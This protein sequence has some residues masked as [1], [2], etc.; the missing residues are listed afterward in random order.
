MKKSSKKSSSRSSLLAWVLLPVFVALCVAAVE[1]FCQL[2]LLKLK[3]SERTLSA[4]D[5]N[6]DLTLVPG[7][8]V[9][10]DRSGYLSCL[11]VI[12]SS[13]Q[14]QDLVLTLTLPDGSTRQVMS[15]FVPS[16]GQDTIR[17]GCE[18]SGLS[19]ESTLC[20]M[21]VTG[22]QTDNRFF[23]HGNRALL[24]ALV[25]ACLWLLIWFRSFFSAKP[26]FA[27]LMIALTVGIYLSVGLPTA[28]GLSWDDQIHFNR[29]QLLSHGLDPRSTSFTDNLY[30]LAFNQRHT[31]PGSSDKLSYVPDTWQDQQAY[32]AMLDHEAE[33]DTAWNPL[34]ITH[35]MSDVGYLL[36]A[37][38]MGLSRLLGLPFHLQLIGARLFNMLGY[39][40]FAFLGIRKL[41]RFRLTVSCIALSPLA[42]FLAGNLSYDATINGL[43]FFGVC[44]AVDA[45]LDRKTPLTCGRGLGI[46]LGITLGA[47]V[48]TV[49]MPLLLLVLLLPKE[50]F[51]STAQRVLFKA[52][53][54]LLCAVA[55]GS[56]V[57]NV[58]S[59]MD[60][61]Y[62]SRA[63]GANA[64]EQ[65]AFVLGQP[66]VYAGYLIRYLAGHITENLSTVGQLYPGVSETFRRAVAW[67]ACILL[68]LTALT[69]AGEEKG[70]GYPIFWYQ[71]VFFLLIALAVSGLTC[72]VLY[73][74]FTPVGSATFKGVQARYFLPVLP[75]VWTVLCPCSV[76][77]TSVRGCRTARALILFAGELALLAVVCF[78]QFQIP[79]FC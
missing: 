50:K 63:E 74:S 12:G 43:C 37:V 14:G 16:L 26:E 36:P 15:G 65:I 5:L 68:A 11:T 18:V 72:S 79:F 1:I 75:L 31:A 25:A 38:G 64:Q 46:L 67:P 32:A 73:A 27:F 66:F 34:K 69:D 42:L 39:V 20:D 2:P 41:H 23:L 8:P 24:T 6:E 77:F 60:A 3:E 78:T 53:T 58:T 57:L 62:D 13:E 19:L 52:G 49:Y 30:E 55:I 51:S 44:L 17:I 61:L 76:S 40:L 35:K 33:V 45:I 71:K 21:T 10:L 56:M 59:D 54:V 70:P 7:Q 9:S 4:F 28:L 48:K 47:V 29:I 22:M